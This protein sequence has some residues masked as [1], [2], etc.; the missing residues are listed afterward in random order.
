VPVVTC[1]VGL[2]GSGKTPLARYLEVTAGARAFDGLFADSAEGRVT[3]ESFGT[4]LQSGVDCC[5][6]EVGLCFPENR[7]AFEQA[8]RQ[9]PMY[10]LQWIFFAKDLE[11]AN[12]NVRHGWR[13]RGKPDVDRHLWINTSQ[14]MPRYCVPEGADVRPIVRCPVDGSLP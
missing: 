9:F 10:T 7:A 12:W 5:V 6:E 4:A 8:M 14:L 1:L 3:R 11:S 2:C 13:F